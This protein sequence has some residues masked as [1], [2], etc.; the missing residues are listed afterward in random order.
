MIDLRNK[1]PESARR[2]SQITALIIAVACAV[3]IA[4]ALLVS[5]ND[6]TPRPDT[7]NAG[8]SMV[9]PI[10]PTPQPKNP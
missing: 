10:R 8:P 3:V 5:R 9:Q 2:Q 1:P 4:I 7:T 6:T